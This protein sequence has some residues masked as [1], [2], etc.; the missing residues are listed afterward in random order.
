[1]KKILFL[2]AALLCLASCDPGKWMSHHTLDWYIKNTSGKP[3][4]VICSWGWGL[5]RPYDL[6]PGDSICF[7]S[8]SPFR[9]EG[10]PT[11]DSLYGDIP[12][13]NRTVSLLSGDGKLL[14]TWSVRGRDAGGRQ[15]FRE[16]FWRKY[17]DGPTPHSSSI[18]AIWVFDV[19]PED[20]EGTP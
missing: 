5:D 14:K 17:Q 11:F 20:I 1:M 12:K 2:A 6:P 15:L 10:D 7:Y 13:E 9:F 8:H 3:F 19:L 18:H 4:T 16:S